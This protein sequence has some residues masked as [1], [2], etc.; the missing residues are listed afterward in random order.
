ML[1]HKAGAAWRVVRRHLEREETSGEMV[2]GRCEPV[3]A[4]K[5]VPTLRELEGLVG[6]A[7][8]T[9]IP[10]SAQMRK[11]SGTSR[12]RFAPTDT[13]HRFYWLPP[14]GDTRK[15]VR[16]KGGQRLATVQY[17]D[18]NG[19]AKNR[20]GTLDFSVRSAQV[21]FVADPYM[22]DGSVEEFTI[23]RVTGRQFFGGWSTQTGPTV[24]WKGY[25]CGRMR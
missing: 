11:Y 9:V 25:F 18:P 12:Y 21:I 14:P 20:P 19:K 8:I 13:L 17:I 7:D 5:T 1:L 4:P 16:L 6:D 10:T 15:P 3:D 24:P 2:A 23:L 22:M